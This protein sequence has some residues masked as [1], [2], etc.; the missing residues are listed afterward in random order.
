MSGQKIY[1]YSKLNGVHRAIDK[2][3]TEL[4]VLY[5]L[6]TTDSQNH[7]EVLWFDTVFG[8]SEEGKDNMPYGWSEERGE[9][10]STISNDKNKCQVFFTHEDTE[11]GVGYTDYTIGIYIYMNESKISNAPRAV[12]MNALLAHIQNKV[13]SNNSRSPKREILDISNS[14]RLGNNILASSPL[15]DSNFNPFKDKTIYGYISCK[16]R[17]AMECDTVFEIGQVYKCG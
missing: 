4:S 5:Y 3:Q 6:N 7:Q 14:Q 2:L 8:L 10:I 15:R 1:R 12:A 13:F 11:V 9:H 16:I 17:V